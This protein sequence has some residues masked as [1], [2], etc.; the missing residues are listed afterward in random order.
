MRSP[1][2]T[3][4]RFPGIKETSALLEQVHLKGEDLTETMLSTFF[5]IYENELLVAVG[6]M[7]PSPP[8][9]LLRSFATNP[10]HQGQGHA[11]T[12]LNEVEHLAGEMGIT[13]IYL[14]TETAEAYFARKGYEITHRNQAPQFIASTTQFKGLCPASAVFM[15]KHIFR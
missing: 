3:P 14:L 13:H 1:N 2:T 11:S 8:F 12:I 10:E 9:A 7:E 4:V 5:G 6:G 15:R